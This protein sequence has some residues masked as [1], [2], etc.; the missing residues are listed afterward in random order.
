MRSNMGVAVRLL[1]ELLIAALDTALISLTLLL[2]G[3][4]L[5]SCLA[6]GGWLLKRIRLTQSQK[7]GFTIPVRP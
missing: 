2:I 3:R 5:H 4:L 6:I 1:G 7:Q